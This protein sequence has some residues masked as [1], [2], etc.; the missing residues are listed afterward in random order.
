MDANERFEVVKSNA[1]GSW[2]G[3]YFSGETKINRDNELED[4]VYYADCRRDTAEEAFKDAMALKSLG[5]DFEKDG[6]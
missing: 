6:F 3:K 5:G 2:I 4:V 1:T